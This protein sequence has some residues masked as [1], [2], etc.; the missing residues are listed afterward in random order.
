MTSYKNVVKFEYTQNPSDVVA[1]KEYILFEDGKRGK[2]ALL[3]F[4]NNLDQQ[5]YALQIEAWQFDGD[6]NLI[7][8]SVVS[9]DKFTAEAGET[10]VPKAKLKLSVNCEKITIKLISAHF[11]RVKWENGEFSDNAY[12]FER[13]V[14]DEKP[15]TKVKDS[16]GRKQDNEI[17]AQVAA[18]PAKSKKKY[19]DFRIKDIMRENLAKFPH[20]FGVFVFLIIIAF[21]IG[22]SF[23]V[24]KT[25]EEFSIGDFDVVKY[26]E[27]QLAIVGYCGIEQDVVIPYELDGY[28]VVKIA[29]GAFRYSRIKSVS[30]IV[31]DTLI[32]SDGAFYKCNY[33]T[34]V[35]STG[36]GD[37]YVM[38]YGFNECKN[39][40]II[41]MSNAE[42]MNYGFNGSFNVMQC[43]IKLGDTDKIFG[44]KPEQ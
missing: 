35:I 36:A 39:I 30:F 13:Y 21:V 44:D 38:G 18:I 41:D 6:G 20:V 19:A 1:L 34:E 32:I 23:Y 11:D 17:N 28:E 2:Y 26:S 4:V 22:T 16:K 31:E 27:T 40:E 42:V 24:R 8:K 12:T 33:L 9:H 37:A 25:S 43:N 10:F 7:A 5:L 15:Q 14:G 3:K 29:D